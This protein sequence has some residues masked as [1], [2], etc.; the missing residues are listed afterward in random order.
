MEKTY[1][2][3]MTE[4]TDVELYDRL[5]QYGMFS[6]K[7]PPI[8][9]AQ[10]FLDYCKNKRQQVFAEKWYKYAVYENMRNRNIPRNIG[11]PT[12]MGHERLCKCLSDNW[13]K[14]VEHFRIKTKDQK[15]IVSRIHI[16]KMHGTDAL[17]EMNYKNWRVD[18]TPEPEIYI[19]KKYMVSAD[20]AKCYPSIYTHA[21]AWALAGK[22]VAKN[23]ANDDTLWYNT[24]D[25]Q[26][27]YCKNGETHGIL[28]G[29]HTSN[30]LSEIIL[31]SIDEKLSYKWDYIRH[32]D[33]YT[34]YVESHEDAEKFLVDLNRELREYGLLVNHKKTSIKELPIGT[35]DQ[36]IHKIQ[37]KVSGF[38]KSKPYVDY[39]EVQGFLDFCIKLMGENS[40]NNSIL[41]YALKV[42]NDYTLTPNAQTYVVKSIV[43]LSLIYPYLVPLLSEYIFKR[44]GVSDDD[45]ERYANMIFDKYFEKNN[46]EA[47]AYAILFVIDAKKE[48]RRI[49]LD[50]IIQAKDCVLLLLS[51]I[52]CKQNNWR[53]GVSKLQKFAK[54]LRDNQEMEEYWLFVYECLGSGSLKDDWKPLKKAKVSF[55]EAEY[56]F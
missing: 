20:I 44:Y 28:I 14:I 45:I 16:R 37:D 24:I 12:P 29:P 39:K 19:G 11:I 6:E 10:T 22:S 47:C 42:L 54:E 56:Q 32:I 46:Y 25:K 13:D 41:Y 15:R 38:Q 21:I 26:T 8:L 2:D 49:N 48:I 40:D 4:I 18:G 55:L 35:V 50:D 23:T 31:C 43:A 17:F 36:W 52:Y 51:L 3:F 7:L 53:S 9:T 34:C 5:V 33:D 27:Q 30:I 1:Y